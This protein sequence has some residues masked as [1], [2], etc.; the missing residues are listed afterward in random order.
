MTY[1]TLHDIKE[2]AS[3]SKHSP[4]F[5]SND[6]LARWDTTFPLGIE[7][8][9]NG[10]AFFLTG[11]QPDPDLPRTYSVHHIDAG[12]NI[13]PVDAQ[14]HLPT[15]PRQQGNAPD[16]TRLPTFKEA[17]NKL[18]IAGAGARIATHAEQ[19]I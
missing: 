15:T 13:K 2:A 11:E 7:P 16:F 17:Q 10:G 14:F 8:D 1:R 3:A 5:F 9:G 4:L 19:P 18:A 6:N 12:G